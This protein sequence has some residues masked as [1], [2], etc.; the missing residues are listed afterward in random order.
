MRTLNKLESRKVSILILAAI[1]IL[2]FGGY[3][4]VS[5]SK[6]LF[7]KVPSNIETEKNGKV[8]I[9]GKTLPDTTVKIGYGIVGDKQKSDKKGN[10]KLVYDLTTNSKETLKITAENATDKKIANTT[11]YLPKSNANSGKKVASKSKQKDTKIKEMA[12]KY[13][14][15]YVVKLKDYDIIYLINEHTKRLIYTTSDDHSI[16]T[17]T[18]N[19]NFNDG[20]DF[21]MD[22]LAMRAHYKYLNQASTL[23][24][25]DENGTENKAYQRSPEHVIQYY[26][27]SE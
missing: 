20:I 4:L 6:T 26:E 13:T 1:I 8:T 7:I 23:I 21:N 14:T 22:G 11:V 9:I 15:A 27:L 10:F 18:Y 2:G 5:N 12:K 16:S 25:S 3:L 24:I 19:G 17:T